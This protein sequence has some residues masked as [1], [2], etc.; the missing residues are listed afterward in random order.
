MTGFEVGGARPS[1]PEKKKHSG[2]GKKAPIVATIGSAVITGAGIASI[3]ALGVKE[4]HNAPK[5]ITTGDEGN[6]TTLVQSAEASGSTPPPGIAI[7]STPEA[8][9]VQ[10]EKIKVD[11]QTFDYFKEIVLTSEYDGLTPVF[12]W[13]VSPTIKVHGNPP[14]EDMQTL[15]K[16]VGELNS[17]QH[18]ITL[19]IVDGDT[20][21]NIDM[22]FMPRSQFGIIDPAYSQ[23]EPNA[24]GWFNIKNDVEADP[25]G[26]GK[27]PPKGIVLVDT[28]AD[29][30]FRK[31]LIA[32][33]VS[34]VLGPRN[35]SNMY[36]DSMWSHP[37][38]EDFSELDKKVIGMLYDPQIKNGMSEKQVQKVVEITQ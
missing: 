35:D 26:T 24:A 25:S 20:K 1:L 21:A 18:Q 6:G 33:E 5:P 36:P 28:G 19:S 38:V 13:E 2:V 17:F 27:L 32:E 30:K 37:N 15:Q 9:P 10:L 16:I 12:K 31:H 34:Q 14:P 4:G 3:F 11:Q 29:P 22:Y 7:G 8:S 23:T